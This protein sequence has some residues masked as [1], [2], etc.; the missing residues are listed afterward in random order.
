MTK[1]LKNNNNNNNN[2]N[3]NVKYINNANKFNKYEK[4][5]SNKM[6]STNNFSTITPSH[7][8]N[9]TASTKLNDPFGINPLPNI[10]SPY[11][12][13][14]DTEYM[15]NLESWGVTNN[16]LNYD[17]ND[18]YTTFRNSH[19]FSP[20]LPMYKLTNKPKKVN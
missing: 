13:A 9:N 2:S 14:R 16:H 19:N 12:S 6:T 3:N 8:R 4:T 17:I 18:A 11:M 10:R 15:P 5:E 7:L 20:L 1:I